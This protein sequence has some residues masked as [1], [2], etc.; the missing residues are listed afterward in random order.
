MKY[1]VYVFIDELKRPYYVGK[2]NNMKRRR[3]EHLD[4]IKKGNILPKYQK[5]RKLLRKG[6]KFK[7]R[8]IRTTNSEKEAYRLE[9]YYIRKYKAENYMLFNCT[10][11]GPDEKFMKIVAPKV[12]REDGIKLPIKKK[13][14]KDSPKK[15][16]NK[17]KKRIKKKK[18]VLTKR[19]R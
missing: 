16:T 10:S 6:I 18:K 8:T 12:W 5:A 7:M 19:K 13:K 15:S 3:K 17:L 11:G 14:K 1:S 9:R 4:E 2:T